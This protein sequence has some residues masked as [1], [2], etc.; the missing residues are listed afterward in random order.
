MF[1]CKKFLQRYEYYFKWSLFVK[2]K[3]VKK[4][5]LHNFLQ[6]VS[7]I[8]ANKNQKYN[9]TRMRMMQ[10]YDF[11]STDTFSSAASTS[12][13]PSEQTLQNIRS[14]ARSLQVVEVDGMMIE[15]YLN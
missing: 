2:R 11:L 15:L 1:L 5:I 8:Q 10:H 13:Q 4:P 3:N 6:N 7:L 12:V 9:Q 14:F